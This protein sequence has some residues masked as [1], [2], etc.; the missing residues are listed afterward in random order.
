MLLIA[1]LGHAIA[2]LSSLT[3]KCLSDCSLLQKDSGVDIRIDYSNPKSKLAPFPY[4]QSLKL[5]AFDSKNDSIGVSKEY[6]WPKEQEY[7]VINF[8]PTE[9]ISNCT[10]IGLRAT[11]IEHNHDGTLGGYGTTILQYINIDIGNV[12]TGS[13]P[14]VIAASGSNGLRGWLT[15]AFLLIYACITS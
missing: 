13:G 3:S 8:K 14:I 11:W 9:W 15:T 1:L 5:R 12:G 10:T 2:Q 6:D 4:I 7:L